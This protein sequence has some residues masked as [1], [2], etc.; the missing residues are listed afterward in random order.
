LKV[1]QITKYYYPSESFGGPVQVSY[2]LSKNLVRRGH[3]V[4]VFSTDAYDIGSNLNLKDHFRVID[5]AKVYFF[6]N[7]IRSHGF[8]ISPGIINALSKT[9]GD[10]DIV[11]LHEYRTFQNLAFYFFNKVPTPYVLSPHGELEYRGESLDFFVLRRLFENAFGKKLLLNASAI[12]ALTEFEKDQL[13]KM[14]V[15]EEIIEIVPNAVDPQA[16]SNLPPKGYFKNLFK[17]DD[18]KI[19]LF[20]GR[21][22][23]LKGI[24]TLIKAFSL[25]LE[26]KHVKLVIIGSDD[27]MLKSLIKLVTNLQLGDKVLFMGY[28]NRHLVHAALND[29]STVVYATQQE[30][31]PLVPIEAAMAGKPVIVSDHPS[32]AFVEKGRFGLTVKYGNIVQLKDAIEKLLD[33]PLLTYELGQNGR[34]YVNANFSWSAISARTEAVYSK[35]LQ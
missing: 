29:A 3:D 17:L 32:M 22:N 8:F 34:K 16:F 23:A 30:G 26:K 21:L 28:L 6:H 33:S 7:F 1:L 18:D 20:I 31:F 19:V 10:F 11:H 35:I 9:S 13:I 24:D 5:G 2:N 12:F 27:G 4:T 14:G 25:L 15:Q